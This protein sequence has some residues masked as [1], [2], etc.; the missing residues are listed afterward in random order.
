MLQQS[1]VVVVLLLGGLLASCSK[2][3]PPSVMP[4][5]MKADSKDVLAQLRKG[6]NPNEQDSRGM[7][8]L[9]IAA[10]RGHTAIVQTLLDQGA[11]IQAKEA[12]QGRTALFL[13]VA[14]GHT[15]VVQALL[16]KGADVKEKDNSGWTPLMLAAERGDTG[17][18]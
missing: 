10:E 2:G 18:A 16:S 13:A 15:P 7:T 8:A 5:V 11:D 3:L 12:R 6:A 9:M 1:K 14:H 17:G 4:A